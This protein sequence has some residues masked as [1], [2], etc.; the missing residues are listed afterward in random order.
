MP[1]S[2]ITPA[3]FTLF[4][5]Y[6]EAYSAAKRVKSTEYSKTAVSFTSQETERA[7]IRL[8]D[9]ITITN[10]KLR[11]LC[12]PREWWLIGEIMEELKMNN[13][14]WA[15]DPVRKRDNR[16]YRD[17]IKGLITKE[18]LVQTE[19]KHM[20]LVNPRHLRRGDV[21][22]CL[23]TTARYLQNIP[24]TPDMIVDRQSTRNF[25]F[26]IPQTAPVAT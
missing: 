13:A 11:S 22:A 1:R 12:T 26:E 16:H 10:P 3:F 5:W 18:I 7:Q 8:V 25:N 21:F 4:S 23:A 15:A 6:G 20:Y 19:T 9:P 2:A 24:P 14:L 17:A